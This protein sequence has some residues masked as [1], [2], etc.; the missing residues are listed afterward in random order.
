MKQKTS[1]AKVPLVIHSF[2]VYVLKRGDREG[3]R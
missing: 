1:S 3:I 2:A